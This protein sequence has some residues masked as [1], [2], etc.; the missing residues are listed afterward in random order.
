MCRDDANAPSRIAVG[1]C[2]GEP[3]GDERHLQ[4]G[5]FQACARSEATDDAEGSRFSRSAVRVVRIETEWSPD[6]D[7]SARWKIEGR[8]HDADHGVWLRIELNRAPDHAR[9][10]AELPLP[11]GLT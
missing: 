8:R 6:V 5:L 10:S 11:E 4:P 7:R 9:R 2:R 1:K 3:I